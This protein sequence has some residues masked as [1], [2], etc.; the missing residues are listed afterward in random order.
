MSSRHCP[1]AS[2]ISSPSRRFS[3]AENANRSQWDRHKSPRTST[4]RLAASANTVPTSV[5]G[6][7]VRRSSGSPRQSANISRSPS[8][9]CETR[10]CSSAKYAAPWIRGRTRLPSVHATSPG[11]R[12]SSRVEGLPRSLEVRNHGV[13]GNV[14]PFPQCPFWRLSS[15]HGLHHLVGNVYPCFRAGAQLHDF[16]VDLDRHLLKVGEVVLANAGLWPETAYRGLDRGAQETPL[17]GVLHGDDLKL[18]VVGSAVVLA[19]SGHLGHLG[20]VR[21]HDAVKALAGPIFQLNLERTE[22]GKGPHGHQRLPYRPLAALLQVD[23]DHRCQ[24]E[25]DV[26]VGISGRGR[27]S[28]NRQPEQ[29]DSGD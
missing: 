20:D 26:G 19:D 13:V 23:R 8:R 5:S 9:I 21:E 12:L 17:R 14:D 27:G 22:T 6:L 18:A 7:P 15:E 10:S 1:P 4:P 2:L 24:A 25:P 16:T 11:W 29:V 28:P 3:C